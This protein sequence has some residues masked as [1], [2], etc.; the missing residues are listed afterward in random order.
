[1]LASK[2]GQ[3]L[4]CTVLLSYIH[5]CDVLANPAFEGSTQTMCVSRMNQVLLLCLL[6]V[7]VCDALAFVCEC[8]SM[9]VCF[10]VYV[11]IYVCTR[12]HARARA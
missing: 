2:V 4:E 12:A 8:V 6:Y 7:Q 5:L 9:S 11:C 1:M 3:N 10:C